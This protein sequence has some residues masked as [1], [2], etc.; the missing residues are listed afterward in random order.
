MILEMQ[1]IRRFAY[2]I[3][4]MLSL[5]YGVFGALPGLA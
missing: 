5:Q 4:V 3:T 1:R 2:P